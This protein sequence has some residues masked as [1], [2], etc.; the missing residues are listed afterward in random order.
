MAGALA[1]VTRGGEGDTVVERLRAARAE[2]VEALVGLVDPILLARCA[3]L[4]GAEPRL[5][6]VAW[7][8]AVQA[9]PSGEDGARFHAWTSVPRLTLRGAE[10][11]ESLRLAA[12]GALS[13]FDD[14]VLRA[15][16]GDPVEVS[17]DR[18]G[19]IAVAPWED[20]DG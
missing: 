12:A 4:F 6:S 8:Q 2:V 11:P 15:R 14:E 17:L 9:D 20:P 3:G 7:V 10:A 16:F 19:R 13:V 1:R 5:V 18:A